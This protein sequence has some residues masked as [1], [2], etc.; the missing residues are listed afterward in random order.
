MQN[1]IFNK[2][3]ILTTAVKRTSAL[4]LVFVSLLTFLYS[5][6]DLPLAFAEEMDNSQEWLVEGLWQGRG[7]IIRSQTLEPLHV[8]MSVLVQRQGSELVVKDCSKS[9]EEAGLDSPTFVKSRA[10]QTCLTTRFE[11]RD[12]SKIFFRAKPV[13]DLFPN[14]LLS[15]YGNRQVSEMILAQ[16]ITINRLFYKYQYSNFDGLSQTRW[17]ELRR[18]ELL[19][20][21]Q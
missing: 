7:Y 11:I 18:S 20:R 3:Y 2:L 8:E 16:L 4:L 15:F 10:D 19:Y 9:I 13:G 17:G 1:I 6:F 21:F 5:S 14:K 12:S